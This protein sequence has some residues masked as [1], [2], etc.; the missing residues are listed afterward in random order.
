MVVKQV[1]CIE[2]VFYNG[3]VA[4]DLLPL[5]HERDFLFSSSA[6]VIGAGAARKRMRGFASWNYSD[7]RDHSIEL[8]APGNAMCRACAQTSSSGV[9]VMQSM[10]TSS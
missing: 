6:A 2:P 10:P 4:C 5:F 1:D 8:S 7:G 9:F 3:G